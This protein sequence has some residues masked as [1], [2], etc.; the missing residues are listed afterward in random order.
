MDLDVVITDNIDKLATFGN[1]K[2]FGVINDFNL[3]TKE[4]NSSIMKFNNEIATDLVWKP[5]LQDKANLMKLQGDQ[6]AMSRLVMNSEHK[7]VMPD[8]WT[9]SYKWYSRQDPRFDKSRWTFENKESA[10]VAVFHGRPWPH[11]SE[12]KWVK[13]AWN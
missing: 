6:N 5:F 3:K 1:D 10:S 9:F 8:E 7:K 12:Q 2:T 13:E 4:Y 11:E